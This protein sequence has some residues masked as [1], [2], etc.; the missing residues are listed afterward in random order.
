MEINEK[1]TTFL[2]IAPGSLDTSL[3]H[4]AGLSDIADVPRLTSLSGGSGSRS[5]GTIARE[6]SFSG[7]AKRLGVQHSTVSRRIPALEKKLRYSVGCNAKRPGYV[8]TLRPEK[9]RLTAS[10]PGAFDEGEDG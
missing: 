9:S 4:A 7:A 5:S 1:S 3:S 10:P 6:G 2:C 8:L